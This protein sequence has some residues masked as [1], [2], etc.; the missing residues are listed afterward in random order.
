MKSI[1]TFVH[2]I[3]ENQPKLT[4]IYSNSI[5]SREKG[6]KTPEE[7]SI[8][9]GPITL[10]TSILL[11]AGATILAVGPMSSFLREIPI[12]WVTV[13]VPLL[14]LVV[15]KK[16]ECIRA[17]NWGT[18]TGTIRWIVLGYCVLGVPLKMGG[19]RGGKLV[20]GNV[21]HCSTLQLSVGWQA[22]L[23]ALLAIAGSDFMLKWFFTYCVNVS[24]CN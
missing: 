21:N 16:S 6:K 17:E 15:Q 4:P 13:D 18:A 22:K 10:W 9:G 3:I 8:P 5:L 20:L 12:L 2:Q 14:C 24:V 7:S 11:M 19:E 23:Q 1:Y